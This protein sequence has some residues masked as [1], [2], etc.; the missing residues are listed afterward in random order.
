MLRRLRARV[1]R[2]YHSRDTG[3][4]LSGRPSLVNHSSD[5]FAGKLSIFTSS[6]RATAVAAIMANP[7]PYNMRQVKQSLVTK[8]RYRQKRRW[9]NEKKKRKTHKRTMRAHYKQRRNGQTTESERKT[10]EILMSNSFIYCTQSQYFICIEHCSS[11]RSIV[12]VCVWAMSP[13]SNK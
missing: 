10:L 2:C 1:S 4:Y 9:T 6:L 12:C 7:D 3:V 5:Q 8:C 13:D 11:L